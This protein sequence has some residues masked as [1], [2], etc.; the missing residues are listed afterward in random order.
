MRSDFADAIPDRKD[1]GHLSNNGS[2]TVYLKGTHLAADKSLSL[3]R[4][5]GVGP[6]P[7]QEVDTTSWSASD[8]LQGKTY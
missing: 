2:T 4:G 8:P 3:H 1:S 5:E 6:E 7:H